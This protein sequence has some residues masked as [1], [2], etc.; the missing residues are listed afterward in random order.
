M[1]A[2]C[3]LHNNFLWLIEEWKFHVFEPCSHA[4]E[5]HQVAAKMK[6]MSP[7]R[8]QNSFYPCWPRT[9]G[10]ELWFHSVLFMTKSIFVTNLCEAGLKC[11]TKLVQLYPWHIHVIPC[12]NLLFTCI[13]KRQ[14]NSAQWSFAWT[15]TLPAQHYQVSF[16]WKLVFLPQCRVNSYGCTVCKGPGMR[17]WTD[18]WAQSNVSHGKN[19]AI[20]SGFEFWQTGSPKK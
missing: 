17:I 12:F 6:E 5:Y 13:C 11:F 16:L 18:V 9:F 15:S 19:H 20:T 8:C 2:T 7:E 1:T 4:G 10:A 3:Q 14:N